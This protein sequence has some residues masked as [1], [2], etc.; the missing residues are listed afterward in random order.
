MLSVLV[1]NKI[2]FFIF[3]YSLVLCQ[4]LRTRGAST[5]ESAPWHISRLEYDRSMLTIGKYF[6]RSTNRFFSLKR[7]VSA[8]TT[9]SSVW[10]T[11]FDSLISSSEEIQIGGEHLFETFRCFRTRGMIC[12][13]TW[14]NKLTFPCV[15]LWGT[16]C[17]KSFLCFIF[18][19]LY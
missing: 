17:G 3:W 8:H 13:E 19:L 10:L 2:L 12:S 4:N 1:L 14:W 7:S 18:Y 9:L 11:D 5:R 16:I 15:L 6:S